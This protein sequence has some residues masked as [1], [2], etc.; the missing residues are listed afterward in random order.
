MS[1]IINTAKLIRRN[2]KKSTFFFGVLTYGASY[3]KD[4]FQTH[5]MMRAYC[6]EARKYGEK[7]LAQMQKP[8]HVTVILNP[9]A[10]YKKSNVQ[11]EKFAAPLLHLAGFK[12]SVFQTENEKQ[13]TDL[14]KVMSNT[15]AVLVAGG[16]GT[17]QEAVT[18][19]MLRPNHEEKTIPLGIV[20]LGKTNTIA[21]YLFGDKASSRAQLMA[22]AVMAVIR[23]TTIKLDVLKIQYLDEDQPV[24]AMC[25]FEQGIFADVDLLVQKYW[26]LGGFKERFTYLINSFKEWHPIENFHLEYV[27]PCAGC[28]KCHVVTSQKE[29]EDAPKRWWHAFVPRTTATKVTDSVNASKEDLSTRINED[30]G[31]RIELPPEYSTISVATTSVD[32]NRSEKSGSFSIKIFP[33]DLS[34]MQFISSGLSHR[35]S[36]QHD[37]TGIAHVVDARELIIKV[38]SPPPPEIPET[39]TSLEQTL[40]SD[41]SI[42][43]YAESSNSENTEAVHLEDSISH[44][45]ENVKASPLGSVDLIVERVEASAMSS[46]ASLGS[47]DT[48]VENVEA[49]TKSATGVGSVDSNVENV[50]ASTNNA[51]GL[52][53]VDTNVE[54]VEASSNNAATSES[55]DSNAANGSESSV[56]ENSNFSNEESVVV[57]KIQEAELNSEKVSL[58]DSLD[59]QTSTQE[60]QSTEPASVNEP[61]NTKNKEAM[62]KFSYIDHEKYKRASCRISIL[63]KQVTI[64]G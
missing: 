14:M 42:S 52:G 20:P 29:K 55:I 48:N 15:D 62:E 22:E 35:K 26:Y 61:E 45:I 17:L 1:R 32:S 46:S 33:K 41:L 8:R 6:E 58:E 39:T 18:G 51:T 60:Q 53:S 34:M 13:A 9:E 28:S 49:S 43:T 23:E 38:D 63:P 40:S 2:W 27:A 50:G 36:K 57:D 3:F 11:F 37:P 30:C 4:K 19:L 24:F 12:V 7:P 64:F 56:L 16:N 59:S 10:N 5:Q 47:V 21:E 54:N 44:N 25:N 31:K